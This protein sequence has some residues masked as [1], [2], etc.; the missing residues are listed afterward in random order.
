MKKW[1]IC[2]FLCTFLLIGSSSAHAATTA[3]P[4][5]KETE[6]SVTFVRKIVPGSEPGGTDSNENNQNIITKPMDSAGGKLPQT[7]EES[8]SFYSILGLILIIFSMFIC[9]FRKKKEVNE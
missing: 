2:G 9:M 4:E 8:T 3:E 6:V 1:F 5:I 7:G